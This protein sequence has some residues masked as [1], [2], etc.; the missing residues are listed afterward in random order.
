MDRAM[1]LRCSCALV[2]QAQALLKPERQAAAASS[3][4]RCLRTASEHTAFP[5]VYQWYTILF[6]G[7]KYESSTIQSVRRS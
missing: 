5:A 7:K 3:A 2:R 4:I 1:P 6:L